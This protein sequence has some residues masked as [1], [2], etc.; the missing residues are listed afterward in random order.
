MKMAESDRLLFDVRMKLCKVYSGRG[1]YTEA[2]DALT[3]LHKAC[4]TSD[5]QDD[6]KTKGS[7]LLEIYAEELKISAA[8]GDSVK[9]K[10]L[11]EKTKD[12]TAAVKDPR[13]QSI[14]REC[15]GMMFGDDGQWPRAKA[16]FFSAFTHY[17]EIG[18]GVK[19][20]QCLKYY[21]IAHMLSRSDTNPFDTRE[22]KVYQSDKDIE[23]VSQLRLAYEKCDVMMFSR[24]LD[25]INKANDRFISKHLKAMVLDFHSRSIVSIIKSY[26]R[27]RLAHLARQ[28]HVEPAYIEELLVQLILDGTVM[29]RIDQVKGLLDLSQRSGGGSKKYGALDV[30]SGTLSTLTTN[31]PQPQSSWT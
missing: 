22:V 25:D 15:W 5:G 19:A 3:T 11:Y 6:K 10:E 20:K 28:L 23:A 12:L 13:S 30:W 18:N 9:L 8:M 31:L 24:S 29:G 27:I 7:E 1:E 2:L 26:R 17:D 14:I 4:L 21:V 16:E